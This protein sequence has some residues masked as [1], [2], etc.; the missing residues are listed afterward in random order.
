MTATLDTEMLIGATFAA[1]TEAPETVLNPKTE[2]TLVELPEASADQ[3]DAAVNAA[4]KAFAGWARTTPAERS[5]LL[6][7][8]ADRIEAEAESFATLEALNCGKPR[9]AVLR[10]EIPGVVDCFRFFAGAVRTQH[11]MVAGEYL[12]GHTSMIRRDPIGVVASIAPWNYPLMMAAWKLAPALAGGNTVVIKPS[13]QT[14]LTALKLARLIADIFPEGVVNVVVGRGESVGN[15][16][17]NHPKVAM[18]SLTGDIATGKKVLTAA[19]RSVKRTHLEL[20]GKAPVI[21][22]DDA[23]IAEVVEG[24][25]AFGYYNAGQDCTAACRIYAADRIYDRLVAD[26]A[27]AVSGLK[28]ASPNDEENDIGPL[29]SARQRA[30]VASFVER[31]SE[32]GHIEIATGGKLAPGKGFFYEPTVVAGALQSD[33][34]VRREVFGPVVSVT[35]FKE[36]EDAVAWAND[37]DYG[38]ASSVWTKDISRGMATA[39]RLQYGCT[40]VNCHFM[41][42]SE[43]PHGGL[44]Q[45]GYGKDL[46]AYALEDYTVVRH[47]MVKNG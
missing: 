47:V 1:G 25:K 38:L 37:S 39:A 10:D 43:M 22:F 17:I 6:L 11:G 20:G 29:I 4:D 16:L 23:D 36:V 5:Y 30:R 3:I 24:V 7:K 12:A 32:V 9:H 45:S 8:L 15:A 40:W 26:L 42:V 19:A 14:P 33:E 28:F 44:K 27:S 21:V 35:R 2:E 34:I 18:V 13:E 31:A 46:S 41:L